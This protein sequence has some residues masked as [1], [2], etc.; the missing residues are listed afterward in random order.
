MVWE[1]EHYFSAYQISFY[2]LLYVGLGFVR[3]GTDLECSADAEDTVVG[4]LGRETLEGLLD[5]VVLLGDQVISPG[6][7][8]S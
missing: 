1:M 6:L 2:V 8:V 3:Y 4:L 5:D 7:I